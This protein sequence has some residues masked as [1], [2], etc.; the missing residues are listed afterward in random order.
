MNKQLEKLNPGIL[1]LELFCKGMRIN[2]S[3]DLENDAR[4]VS[5]IRAGL[6]SGLEMILPHNLYANVPILEEFARKSPFL[7]VK[8]KGRYYIT[9]EGSELCQVTIPHQPLWYNS[10]TINGT[11]MSRVGM[12]QGTYLAIYPARV[13]SY[14]LSEPKQNCKFCAT[15]LNVGVSEEEEKSVE[16]VVETA[17][18]A[19]KESRITFVHFNT[20]YCEGKALDILAPYVKAVKEETGILI[21]VQCPP[22]KE[23]SKYDMM[24]ELGV[25]HFSFCFEF[26]NK[27]VFEEVC[28]GKAITLGQETFFRAME[29]TVAKMGKGKV[30]GEIIAGL[31]PIEDTIRAIDYITSIGAFPTICIFRPLTGTDYEKKPSP[32]FEDMLPIFH[33]MYEACKKNSIPTDIAPKIRVSLVVLPYEGRY[34]REGYGFDDS[35]YSCKLAL[36]RLLFRTYYGIKLLLK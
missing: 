1:K 6:G 23:L 16:D 7:L 34:F 5:R 2:P 8:S 18:A 35:I 15:G 31:E 10:R 12:L 22:Q 24:I 19:R 17:V 36:M 28:P 14:W 27:E 32:K 11:L 9:K 29:Y 33:R 30:S 3:C 13:C 21:G 4:L 20:G 25:D 26:F